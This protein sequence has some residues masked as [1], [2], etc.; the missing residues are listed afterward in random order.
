MQYC[1]IGNGSDEYAKA[2]CRIRLDEKYGILRI[3]GQARSLFARNL[4]AGYGFGNVYG[5]LARGEIEPGRT[6][7]RELLGNKTLVCA[8]TSQYERRPGLNLLHVVHF[9]VTRI[10]ANICASRTCARSVRQ[11]TGLDVDK[12]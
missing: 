1:F 10:R 12:I 3:P 6:V 7:G 4:P 9:S 5:T 8:A 2:M 11:T